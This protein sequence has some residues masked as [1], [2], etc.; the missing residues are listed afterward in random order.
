MI[1]PT[2]H[3]DA[4]H[5]VANTT[6]PDQN[7]GVKTSGKR[8]G[9]Q[10]G[11]K[12][13]P[14]TAPLNKRFCRILV[15]APLD[16]AA[17][18]SLLNREQLGGKGMFLRRMQETGL[19]IPPFKCVTAQ[20]M[21]TL[22]QHPLDMGRLAPYLSGITPGMLDEAGQTSLATIRDHLNTLPPSDQAKRDNWLTGL[23]VFIA[24]DDFYQQVKDSEAA[25]HIRDL[26]R[27]LDE[28]SPSQ[29]VIVRS[30]GINEDNYG[31]AQAG[32][33]RSEVQGED[34]VLRTCLKV[35]ASGYRPEV[36]PK[37]E[38]QPMALIIQHCID[39][40][41]GGVV[42]SYQSLQDDTVRVEYTSGQPR[43]AVA[44]QSGTI[45]HRI[46]IDRKAG[47]DNAQYLPGTVSSHF[48]LQKNTDN[49]GYS[50][51]EIQD[52]D[53]P[54]DTGSER[55]C[56]ELVA[57]LRE[58]VTRLED[59]LLCPV[60]VEF[61]IDHEGRLF[62]LQV[63][64]V[65][66]LSGSMDFALSIPEP[67]ETLA[68]G[69]GASEG[70]CTGPL[71]V[72][73]NRA[74]DTLPEGAIVVARH[75]EEWM[76]EPEC[77]ERAAGF[78]FAAGGTN[79][80][81]AITLRQA[82]K[83]CLLAGD[84]Y[85]AVAARD[86]Q[87]AT[88]AC[89]RFNGSPGAFVV[90]G[91]LTGELASHRSASSAFSDEPLTNV[92]ALK[93][94]LSPPEG[95]FLQ[96]ATAF[97]WLTDQNARLLAFFAPGGGL[98]CLTNP[99]KLSMSAQRSEM[100]AATQT[101]TKQLIQG[102]EALLDGYRAFLQLANHS[103]KLQPLLDELPQLMTRFEALKQTIGSGLECITL[104]LQGG[105]KPPVSPGTFRQWV[106]ACHQLQSCL[107]A[108]N[109]WQSGQ[110]RSVHELIFALHQRFVK[111]LGPITLSSGQGRV[112]TKM[113]IT[114]VDCSAPGE[115]A[116][117]LRP[118]GKASIERLERQGTVFSLGDAL[119][120]NLKFGNHVGLIELLEHAEG[121]KGRTLRL[122][123]SDEFAYPDGTDQPGKL[124][125]MWF[126][127]QLLKEI[128]LDKNA[129]S[130][131]LSCN[132]VAGEIIVECP[133][134]TSRQAM[135][136]AFEKLIIVL[137]TIDDLD[138]HLDYRPIVKGDQWSFNL[139]AQRLN[140]DF[141][142]EAN[143]FSFKHCLFSPSYLY[144]FTTLQCY[145]L[146]SNHLQQFIDH[147]QRL[148]KCM[149]KSEAHFREMLMSDEIGEETRRELLHQAKLPL[150]VESAKLP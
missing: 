10:I 33:Y 78:V 110:V 6:N 47:A 95:T 35:M 79:D 139:L 90:A 73:K 53:T 126:L 137:Q 94:D 88:L 51:T 32:K 81:V 54:S 92:V 77:L 3:N 28:L 61:A 100:L 11:A 138:Q 20:V 134:M 18:Y 115:E 102:A 62:L 9:S 125:R 118:S 56:D 144:S 146:L 121:G 129:D 5:G 64:P 85:P 119:I 50:E 7:T 37:G 106:A 22:E 43:G 8:Y 113:K 89:A 68:S 127:A 105:E 86:G 55:L 44:G 72:A 42:M 15:S 93:D 140:S 2:V 76:L 143:R 34:D 23:S 67:E 109:P 14:D 13:T 149:K 150:M 120:I 103:P 148:A 124:K 24:S 29:P 21:N 45:P 63:R 57:E 39:C 66:R 31:D 19:P 59:L 49:N 40:H 84:H 36:C 80:H 65:T 1:Q 123:F 41:Y 4:V 27:Q 12:G 133:R 52:A 130:M 60:D 91:D 30:S 82:E 147:T 122:T 145:P 74:A 16:S 114:Y 70:Y 111:A 141:A 99:I 71:W 142:A 58:A 132:A 48:V 75:G 107:Q 83:P 25:R 101:R 17:D 38:P 26:R 98:D 97:H 69:E 108:L 117:L 87:Q 96:V 116:L 104:P 135:Q 128:E 112:S 46:D 131:K 136:D